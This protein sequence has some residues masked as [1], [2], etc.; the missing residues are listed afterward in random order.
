[1]DGINERADKM[2]GY[3]RDNLDAI[4]QMKTALGIVAS[5][6][7]A[8]HSSLSSVI[9]QL[10]E[11]LNSARGLGVNPSQMMNFLAGGGGFGGGGSFP[12][13][14]AY[15]A[16]M[17]ENTSSQDFST[18]P[19]HVNATIK[20]GGSVK[21]TALGRE[22]DSFDDLAGRGGRVGRVGNVP[23]SKAQQ[24]LGQV[25]AGIVPKAS[26]LPPESDIDNETFQVRMQ[27]R[28]KENYPNIADVIINQGKESKAAEIAYKK[29]ISMVTRSTGGLGGSVFKKAMGNLG[30]D[31][32]TIREAQAEGT[33]VPVRD[34]E[35]NQ[36]YYPGTNTPIMSRTGDIP[37]GGVEEKALKIADKVVDV[38]GSSLLTKFTEFAGY[39]SIAASIYTGAS[40]ISNAIRPYA[41]IA[42][43]QGGAIGQVDYG[44]SASQGL[45]AFIQSGFNLNP[46]WNMNDI[47]QAQ[48]N[49][50][51][52][53]LRGSNIQQYVNTASQF[54]QQY[55]L[56]A[57]QTQQILGGG[58]GVGVDM[59]NNASAFAFIRALENSSQTSSAYGNQAYMSSLATLAGTGASPA[60]AAQLAATSTVGAAGDFIAQANGDTDTSL[61][62]TQLGTA[63]MAQFLGTSYMGTYAA[64]AGSSATKL[65]GAL[66]AT[67]QQ[68]LSWAGIDTT[69]QYKD[70]KEF[71][72]D[73][74]SQAQILQMIMQQVGLS[75]YAG[76]AQAAL[77][78]AW[79]ATNT[80][81]QFNAKGLAPVATKNKS[82]TGLGGDVRGGAGMPTNASVFEK[83]VQ[84]YKSG[85]VTRS[86]YQTAMQQYNE[87]NYMAANIDL[88]AD[89]QGNSSS[90]HQSAS[91]HHRSATS[92]GAT[93]SKQL[94]ALGGNG[95]KVAVEVNL[96]NKAAANINL[97]VKSNT[98]GFKNGSVPVNRQPVQNFSLNV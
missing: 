78:W 73:N 43:A 75:K 81:Q 21:G 7:Q 22:D 97:A 10:Q 47:M 32:G 82:K 86:Q 72:H 48:L 87:G 34:N 28:L 37:S 33:Y 12:Q 71:M 62:G 90:S 29:A 64:E 59:Q 80:T 36:M 42:Q 4:N 93:R 50:Q 23:A 19:N 91:A 56:S 98:S 35:G 57:A 26:D 20:A 66:D 63:L 40:A 60:V 94:S 1:M 13:S 76:S 79:N 70:M 55:G 65:Q 46:F 83:L 41:Q 27:R 49:A 77:A 88:N 69:K 15:S 51:A 9:Q 24:M 61:L 89:L 25:V 84:A 30:V 8:Y 38:F 68:V 39:A 58:L 54:Q 96:S 14:G 6:T 92:D 2:R 17:G 11:M 67:S 45:S 16:A 5:E 53:G 85:S 52:L 44:R 74:M 31:L 18:N 3:W 95:H